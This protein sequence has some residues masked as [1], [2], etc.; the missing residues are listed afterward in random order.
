MNCVDITAGYQ[1]LRLIKYNNIGN[2]TLLYAKDEAI[3]AVWIF[4]KLYLNEQISFIPRKS[5]TCLRISI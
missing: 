4:F 3:V 5:T 1:I 2:N